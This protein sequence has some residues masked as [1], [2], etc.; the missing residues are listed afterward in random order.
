[1][2]ITEKRLLSQC[3]NVHLLAVDL[4]ILSPNDKTNLD[5]GS[6]YYGR[7]FRLALREGGSTGRERHPLG[8]YL[9]MTKTEASEALGHIQTTLYAI[10]NSDDKKRR[11][12]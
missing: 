6:K 4:G 8:D 3:E 7:A 11:N 12:S 2:R 9:G 1:M 10:I 5:I